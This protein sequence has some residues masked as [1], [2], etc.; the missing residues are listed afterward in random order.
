[1][2][3]DANAIA[4]ERPPPGV[5]QPI[6]TQLW[7]SCLAECEFTVHTH[8]FAF[9]S[10]TDASNCVAGVVSP[11]I[12]PARRSTQP[13]VRRFVLLLCRRCLLAQT[14]GKRPLGSLL[15]AC[16]V[17]VPAVSALLASSLSF[18][19]LQ[20]CVDSLSLPVSPGRSLM[21]G[22]IVIVLRGKYAGRK[23]VIVRLYDGGRGDRKFSHALGETL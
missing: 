15:G 11:W 5:A 22:R 1:M 14:C 12:G 7:L 23:A 2:T 6:G 3:A 4:S 9:C 18:S 17:V 21:S 16:R 19:C 20:S 8:V 10:P 13:R